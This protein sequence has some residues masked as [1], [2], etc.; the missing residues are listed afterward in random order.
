MIN[1]PLE[2]GVC[3]FASEF[4]NI[5]TNYVWNIVYKSIIAIMVMVRSFEV[6]FDIFKAQIIST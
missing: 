4:K 3:H 1:G 5:P 2:L 6:I